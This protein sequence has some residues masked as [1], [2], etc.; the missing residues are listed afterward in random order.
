MFLA[1][2]TPRGRAL[3]DREIYLPHSWTDDPDRCAAAGIAAQV[4][5]ATKTVLGRRMLTRALDAGVPAGWVTADR[6]SHA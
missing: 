5:F 3:I 2:A 1:Y 4:G 6:G